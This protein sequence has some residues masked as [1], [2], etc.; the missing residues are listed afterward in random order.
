MMK[1]GGER[2]NGCCGV[3]KENGEKDFR[4]GG[5]GRVGE[6]HKSKWYWVGEGMESAGYEWKESGIWGKASG[7]WKESAGDGGMESAGY[8]EGVCRAREE[9]EM[10]GS[11]ESGIREEKSGS[12][13][14]ENEL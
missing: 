12:E 9:G 13:R 2:K 7:V 1:L 10:A 3:E 4:R 11:N 5:I 6:G 8:G 14:R